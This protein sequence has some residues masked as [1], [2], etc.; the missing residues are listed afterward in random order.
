MS[1]PHDWESDPAAFA[2]CLKAWRAAHGWSWQEAADELRK[3]LGSVQ[4]MAKGRAPQ[5]EASLRRLMTLIDRC[6]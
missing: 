4:Q 5:D 3:P 6:G 1:D 2:A